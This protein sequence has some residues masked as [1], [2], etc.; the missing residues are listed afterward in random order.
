MSDLSPSRHEQRDV[1]IPGLLI[2]AGVLAATV[3]IAFFA[4]WWGFDYLS[5]REKS[6]SSAFPLAAQ[7]RGRLPPEPRLEEVDR[8]EGKMG[9]IRPMELDAADERMLETYGWVDEKAGVVRIPISRAMKIIVDNNL[10]PARPDEAGNRK[11][12]GEGPRP[13]A[14]NSG[15]AVG[16]EQ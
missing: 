1:N 3:A 13:S 14:A 10:F 12:G 8:L 6:K 9:N 11:L 16:R 15:R 5:A 4:A 7:E 2:C